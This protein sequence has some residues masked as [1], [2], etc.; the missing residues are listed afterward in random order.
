MCQAFQRKHVT[1]DGGS[2]EGSKTPMFSVEDFYHG[3]RNGIE[4]TPGPVSH[5]RTLI[6][7]RKFA[8][9]SG[10]RKLPP[11]GTNRAA[12]SFPNWGQIRHVAY[13]PPSWPNVSRETF[14]YCAYWAHLRT[15]IAECKFAPCSARRGLRKKILRRSSTSK[16]NASATFITLASRLRVA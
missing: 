11:W 6:A 3:S 15:L 8:L 10:A 16:D 1:S 12:L 13:S 2:F 7:K 4:L 9:R 14:R 5:G